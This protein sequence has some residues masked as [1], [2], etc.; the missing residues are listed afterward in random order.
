MTILVCTDF[1][2]AAAAGEREAARRF[3]GA[4]LIVF[5]AVD[6]A[7]I[8]R[9]VERTGMDGVELKREVTDFADARLNEIV[10]RLASQGVR[11]LAELT[12]GDPVEAALATAARHRAELVMLSVPA[13]AADESQGA[14]TGRFRAAL[15][16]QAQLPIL[17]IPG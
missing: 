17:I 5:H 12:S 13:V 11:A 10:E 1:T 4:Q 9:V 16:R 14:Q 7:L 6:T 8:A 3:P 15:A 2:A